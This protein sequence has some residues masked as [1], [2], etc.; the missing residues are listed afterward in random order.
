MISEAET[1]TATPLLSVDDLKASYDESIILRGVSMQVKPNSV[2]ALLGRNGV[3]KTSLLR[4][5][6]G[7]MP[8]TEGG[9]SFEGK[10]IA[11]LRSDQRA[12]L[13]LGYVPQGRDIFPNLTVQENLEVSLSISGKA[14]RARLDEVYELFPVIKDMLGRKGGVLSG[15]QQQQ[16]A[17]GRAILTNPKLL[18]LDEPTEG[19]QPS[20][21][22]QIEDAIHLLKK[23]GNLSIILVE[24]YLDFAKSASDEFYI[25]D[26]GS[27]V[28]SGESEG[29]TAEVIGK[30]LTV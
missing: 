10:P 21:I 6:M 7:L 5:I 15:G 19:I 20:I 9:I 4:S 22:D 3:G 28:L 26:R 17:I 24:Q 23:Q 16:L 1:P 11:N 25:L 29:L 18:I 8:K 2:V 27:V 12:R 14:G 30:H 13:G